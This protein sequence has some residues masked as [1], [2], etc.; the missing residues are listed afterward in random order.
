[1][2][3]LRILIYMINLM[4]LWQRLPFRNA[5]F[6]VAPSE[7]RHA[8]YNQL[9]TFVE[10]IELRWVQPVF[11]FGVTADFEKVNPSEKY[12]SSESRIL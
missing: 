1:M 11:I 4:Q 3:L 10:P 2:R 5:S 8:M 12:C 9:R 7:T 6:T